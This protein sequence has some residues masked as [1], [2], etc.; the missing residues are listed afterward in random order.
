LAPDQSQCRWLGSKQFQQAIERR[1]WRDE[2]IEVVGAAARDVEVLGAPDLVEKIVD[3]K[4]LK[5]PCQRQLGVTARCALPHQ[6]F[7]P[8]ASTSPT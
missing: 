2:I 8:P 5:Q 1:R 3:R 4:W 7:S 6:S